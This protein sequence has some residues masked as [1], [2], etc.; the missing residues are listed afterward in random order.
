MLSTVVRQW[1]SKDRVASGRLSLDPFRCCLFERGFTCQYGALKKISSMLRRTL[2]RWFHRVCVSGMVCF[3][4][5]DCS[6]DFVWIVRSRHLGIGCE[7]VG[8]HGLPKICRG[9]DER[10]R[11]ALP[12]VQAVATCGNNVLRC[13]WIRCWRCRFTAIQVGKRG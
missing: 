5:S 11:H 12:A 8:S 10:S 4:G 13:M 7:F 2:V 3:L 1:V 9:I 6:S